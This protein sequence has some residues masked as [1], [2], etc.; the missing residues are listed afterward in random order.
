ME[1]MVLLLP[2]MLFHCDGLDNP[3]VLLSLTNGHRG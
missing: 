1:V 2:V 3:D